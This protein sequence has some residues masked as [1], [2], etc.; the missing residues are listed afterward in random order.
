MTRQSTQM[1]AL[2]ASLTLAGAMLGAT[3]GPL[4]RVTKSVPLG[5]P[6]RWDYVV[7]D[8][9]SHRVYVAHGDRVT[10][11]D[12]QSGT[13]VGEVSGLPGGTHGTAIVTAQ[14]KGYTDDG[15]A[16]VAAAFDLKTLKVIKRIKADADAD[17]VV[18]EPTSGH[19]FVVNGDTGTLTVIDPK[20]DVAVATIQ[21][22]GKLESAVVGASGTLYVNGAAKR[23]ILKID[24]RTNT[25]T[26]RWPVATCESPHGLAFDS[27]A[28]R[29]FTTCRNKQMVIVDAQGG[30]VLGTAPIGAGTD[31]AAFD[32]KRQRAFSSNSQDGTISVIETG[33]AQR[34]APLEPVPTRV[35]GR[36]MDIDPATGRL[37][38]AVATLQDPASRD[39]KVKPGSLELLFLDP[40]P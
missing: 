37:Y 29:L 13:L 10:V 33:D 2:L 36:T 18:Y 17:A 34:F 5:A 12:G 30:S 16:G 40:L 39:R 11:V 27:K 38:V 15:E 28:R 14:G 20:Q 8:P 19:V 9:D 25:I 21:G 26:A 22:G 4:Y 6:D 32:P 1:V 31:G 3:A 24:T 23:E 7:F 35:T